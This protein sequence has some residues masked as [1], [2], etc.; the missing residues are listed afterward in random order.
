MNKVNS[1]AILFWNIT[2]NSSIPSGVLKR[3]RDKFS[4]KIN[5]EGILVIHSEKF[6][7]R[8][9]NMRDCEN[10][11]KNMLIEVW[12]PPKKR[13]PTKPTKASKEKRLQAKKG[14]SDI[15]KNRQKIAF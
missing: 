2:D 12:T 14:R 10:K 6:R 11:L 7:D 8:P 15:K 4:G 5:N 3:F 9:Q 13:K 1:K